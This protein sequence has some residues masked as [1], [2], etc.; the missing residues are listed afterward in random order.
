M[1]ATE[2]KKEIYSLVDE[3]DDKSFLSAMLEMLKE[4]KEKPLDEE[5]KTISL[6]KHLE[7]FVEKNDGLLKRL[8]Q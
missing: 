2:I 8:A 5:G 3:I 1:V 6:L 7:K 4:A